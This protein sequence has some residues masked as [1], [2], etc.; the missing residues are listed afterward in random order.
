M[1]L[2]FQYEVR[3]TPDMAEP[4]KHFMEVAGKCYEQAK[5][6]MEVR[7]TIIDPREKESAGNRAEDT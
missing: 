1:V 6:V 7:L 2:K 3:C 4:M 5:D